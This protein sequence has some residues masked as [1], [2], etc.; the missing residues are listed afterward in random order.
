MKTMT[1]GG[2]ILLACTTLVALTIILGTVAILN[3]N[4]INTQ[5]Q[6]IVDGPLPGTYHVGVLQGFVKEQKG[7]MLE[8]IAQDTPDNK[9]RLESTIAD[10][11]S[12]F[13][14]EMKP[15]EKT[16]QTA[17]GR[18]LF[19]RLGPLHEQFN[20]IWA[21]ILPIS[22]EL[23]TKEALAIWNGEAVPIGL[24]R[25]KLL[26]EMAEQRKSVGDELGRLAIGAG[27]TA[28]FWSMLILAC[29]VISGGLLAFFIV[30]SI[31]Q[32][33]TQA[34]TELS[35]GAEQVASASGQV[36]G[37]SQSLAQ[38]ASEQAASLEETSASS[39]EMASMTRKNAENSQQAAVFMNAVSQRVVDANSTL[40][41]MMKSMQEIGASSGKISKIIKVIDEIAFQTNILALNAAV[42]A[43]RA[44][45][46]GMGFAV[47]ADEV[48]NLAQ[49]SAQAAKDTAGLIEDSISKSA[50]GSKKLGEV[51]SS[52][53]AIT[54]GAGKVKT[55]VD[56]VEASSKEQAQ[57][58]EQISKA[59]SQMD[60]VTQRTAANAEESASASEELSAQSQA[61]MAVVE[62]LQAMVGAGSERHVKS[63]AA[64][65][66]AKSN[67]P[68]AR[69]AQK[70]R[71][72][73]APAPHV[74]SRKS[75]PV[76]AL[77]GPRNAAEFPLD[78]T[79]FKDF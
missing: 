67:R 38:G 22:R 77:A 36:S 35:E 71:Q 17:Q 55:L 32:A 66:V 7:A 18:E 64:K 27:E 54:E 12:K 57:G 43:A 9:G 79:E 30:R 74:S 33:L 28:R 65:P 8:H 24:E 62:Q 75:A 4:H 45:E 13:Q 63:R 31:N 53:Q 42:E 20:R 56:E 51:A 5:V 69:V 73:P 50:E 6:T 58:I 60:E 52:I 15:Y 70:G 29:S 47:V 48:R 37:S 78:D 19:A 40:A 10:L 2:K 44:G 3:I 59:V 21:K 49:R 34:V 76:A 41:D 72:A 26:S 16:I 25:A 14:A 23:K 1:I 61:L 39:E 68:V 46:A 11:G